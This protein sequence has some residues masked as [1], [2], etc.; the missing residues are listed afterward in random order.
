M[1]FERSADTVL[2][3]RRGGG[4]SEGVERGVYQVLTAIQ[5][6][7]IYNNAGNIRLKTRIFNNQKFMI[8]KLKYLLTIIL[9]TV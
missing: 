2:L 7:L 3:V 4:G 9:N 8:I 1:R 6:H 5:F